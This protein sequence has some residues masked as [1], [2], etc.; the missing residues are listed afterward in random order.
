MLATVTDIYQV[1]DYP[2]Q[3]PTGYPY[4]WVEYRGDE[5]QILDNTQ[6]KVTYEFIIRVIQ[7]KFE[8]LK[9]RTEA[10]ETTRDRAYT[11]AEKFRGDNN[12]SLSGVLRTH[13]IRT[14]KEYVENG[15]RIQL[16]I[17]LLVETIEAVTF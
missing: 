7:E 5:S 3:T 8:H 4:A 11:I 17:T 12:L 10:E 1:V 2:L 16:T 13:P 6:D 15:T 9:G 14:E